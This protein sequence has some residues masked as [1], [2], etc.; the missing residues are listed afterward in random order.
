[1]KDWKIESLFTRLRAFQ[2]R[3][4]VSPASQRPVERPPT[5]VSPL[6]VSIGS[7]E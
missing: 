1:M 2:R 4:D 5:A 3:M 6:G 7:L